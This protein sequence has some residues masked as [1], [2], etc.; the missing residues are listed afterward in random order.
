MIAFKKIAAPYWVV[1]SYP[2]IGLVGLLFNSGKVGALLGTALGGFSTYDPII[3]CIVLGAGALWRG[4]LSTLAIFLMA[5]N[6][7]YRP[8]IYHEIY[9]SY[10]SNSFSL[11]ATTYGALVVGFAAR[12]AVLIGRTLMKPEKQA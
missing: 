6:L 12:S 11:L 9:G 1:A 4:R 3:L 7:I 10:F 5:A 8:F 2:I